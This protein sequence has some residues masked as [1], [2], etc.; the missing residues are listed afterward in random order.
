MY[1]KGVG[2]CS[3]IRSAKRQSQSSI[4]ISS[5]IVLGNMGSVTGGT[6]R[7]CAESICG[8][9]GI[10]DY[11][12]CNRLAKFVIGDHTSEMDLVPIDSAGGVNKGWVGLVCLSKG[13]VVGEGVPALVD[14]CDDGEV[15]FLLNIVGDTGS[16]NIWW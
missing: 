11:D 15:I 14:S 2:T 3:P 12:I 9:I 8:G 1:L 13:G 4:S 10:G 6:S 5:P 7:K 16:E